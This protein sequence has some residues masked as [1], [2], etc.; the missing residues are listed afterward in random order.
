MTQPARTG[1]GG[2][3][4]P[5]VEVVELERIPPSS[6]ILASYEVETD[7]QG[8]VLAF[9]NFRRYQGAIDQ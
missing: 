8:N 3:P 1:E 9:R 4:R 2:G 6:T 5:H 7:E